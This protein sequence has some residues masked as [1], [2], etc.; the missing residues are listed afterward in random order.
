MG[1][2]YEGYTMNADISTSTHTQRET[3]EF[4]CRPICHDEPS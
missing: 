4:V 3:F 2:N 1:D